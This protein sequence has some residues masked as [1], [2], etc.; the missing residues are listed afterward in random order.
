[1]AE[2]RVRLLAATLA[3]LAVR[4]VASSSGGEPEHRRRERAQ[5]IRA[6]FERLGPLYIKVG[7]ML[8][9]RPDFVSA[10]TIDELGKLH[11]RVPAAP[12]SE[13]EPVLEAEL[14]S[15]WRRAFR[16][17]DTEHPLGSASLAQVYRVRLADGRTGALK[18]Q[19]PGIRSIVHTDMAVLRTAGKLLAAIRPKFNAVVDVDAMVDL[20]FESV[21]NELDFTTEAGHMELGRA[22]AEEFDLLTVPE[23]LMVTPRVLVQD[24]AG[25]RSIR[26]IA[27]GELAEDERVAIAHDLLAFMYRS[28]FVGRLFHADP[29]PGN[30]FV[31]PGRGASLIDWG[32][33]GRLDRPMSLKLALT[34]INIVQNDGDGAAR[35]WVEMGKP[36]QWADIGGFTGDVAGL[37]PKA[38]TASLEELNFGMTLT[39]VLRHSTNR[40]IKIGPVIPMLGKSFANMEGSIRCL[41]PELSAAEVLQ[42]ELADIVL[43][44]VCETFSESHLAR[45]VV[46]LLLAANG[47]Y[48]HARGI[49]R[50]VSNRDLQIPVDSKSASNQEL[51][52]SKIFYGTLTGVGGAWL[53]QRLKR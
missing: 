43:D 40:G 6:A 47:S 16:H 10:A 33:V 46:E 48:N 35:A 14:G 9:T 17:I 29:H 22:Q 21:D 11:D 18:V 23:V 27:R 31:E 51:T 2:H 49:L 19:R 45:G 15:G 52:A 42:A 8:S 50:D 24:L 28:Y 53:W 41:A 30:I 25:G 36:T 5:A 26:E 1:M 37:V 38:A 44:L 4:E 7:Q 39:R 20:I 3:R 32:M 13:F 12:F 34:L